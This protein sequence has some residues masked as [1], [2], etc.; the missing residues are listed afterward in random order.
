MRPRSLTLIVYHLQPTFD[1]SSHAHPRKPTL[2]ENAAG[3]TRL[4]NAHHR[5]T[6]PTYALNK[7]SVGQET[8]H[9]QGDGPRGE[10]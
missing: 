6:I 1:P 10:E 9:H 8:I 7:V 2:A 4:F 3:L 5:T